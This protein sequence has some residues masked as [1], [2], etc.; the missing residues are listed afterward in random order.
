[1]KTFQ[2]ATLF[3]LIASAMAFAPSQQGELIESLSNKWWNE[4]NLNG[5]GY[6]VGIPSWS[7]SWSYTLQNSVLR[8][9]AVFDI[10]PWFIKNIIVSSLDLCANPAY[11][12]LHLRT[13]ISCQ[14]RPCQ[15]SCCPSRCCFVRSCFRHGLHYR[16]PPNQHCCPW[17]SVRS[18]HGRCSWN[19]SSM[20]VPYQPFH[21]DWIPKGRTWRRHWRWV[22]IR[23]A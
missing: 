18:L 23:L 15:G 22:N 1:M 8:W 4:M 2:I 12:P 7:W 20:L 21:P 3:S 13:H 16:I 10:L 9:G 17:G 6:W 19:H 14:E 11:F 5:E